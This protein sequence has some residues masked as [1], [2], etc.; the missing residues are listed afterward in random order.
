MGRGYCSSGIQFLD[1][2]LTGFKLKSV[3]ATAKLIRFVTEGSNEHVA[4]ISDGTPKI[5]MQ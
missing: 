3:F 1:L 4:Y 5:E 2:L